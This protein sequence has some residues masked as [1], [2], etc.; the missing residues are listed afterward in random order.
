MGGASGNSV[1]RKRHGIQY[2]LYSAMERRRT[3]HS[4]SERNAI[5]D[6]NSFSRCCDCGYRLHQCCATPG[7]PTSNVDFFQITNSTGSTVFLN[8]AGAATAVGLNPTGL[9]SADLNGDGNLDVA[10]ANYGDHTVSIVL[11]NGTGRSIPRFPITWEA[12]S[13]LADSMG[14]SLETA[15][16]DL[17]V[18]N[19]GNNTVSILLNNGPGT[20]ATAVS[21][22]VGNGPSSVITGDFNGDGKLDLAVANQNDHTVSIL[23]GNGDGTFQIPAATYPGGV[24]GVLDVGNLALGDFN[25]D[26]KLDL[27]VTNPGTDQISILLGSGD[28]TFQAPASY[29][30]GATGSQSDRCRCSRFR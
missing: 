14:I 1:D 12:G 3:D 29:S 8:Q 17:A 4:F 24:S 19:F 26:G 20:F 10:V 30:T 15:S 16:L 25:G 18:A 28:G 27:A 22:P 21:Y 7:S 6:D 23:L 9:I 2:V 13:I 11:G 5:D